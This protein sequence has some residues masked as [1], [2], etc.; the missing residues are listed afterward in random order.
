MHEQQ[1]WMCPSVHAESAGATVFAVVGGTPERPH[2]SYL[3][4]G[5]PLSADLVAMVEPV[6]V[7]EVFRL[8]AP[9][10]GQRCGHFDGDGA[11]CRLVAKVVRWM[12]I[13]VERLPRCSIR[14]NCMWW[15]QESA[16]ACRRC[17]QVVT[18]D[19]RA[20]ANRRAIADPDVL[21]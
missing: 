2:A 3:S 5:L 14:G 18:N 11:R 21:D 12:P 13:A 10:A 1:P 8:A 4:T 16:A 6:P 7:T 15:Q 20:P 17:P 9:C 19:L